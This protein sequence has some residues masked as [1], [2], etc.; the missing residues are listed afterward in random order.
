MHYERPSGSRQVA[1]EQ[2]PVQRK[3][4]RLRQDPQDSNLQNPDRAATRRLESHAGSDHRQPT[5][6]QRGDQTRSGPDLRSNQRTDTRTESGTGLEHGSETLDWTGHSDNR[7]HDAD[8]GA[9]DGGVSQPRDL[10]PEQHHEQAPELVAAPNPTATH[11]INRPTG[12][13]DAD[14]A[15]DLDDEIGGDLDDE[16]VTDGS[17]HMAEGAALFRPLELEI[18]GNSRARKP[19]TEKAYATNTRRLYKRSTSER[20]TD[21]Q[22][23]VVVTPLD[24]TEDLIARRGTGADQYWNLNRASLLW[25]LAKNRSQYEIFETAF[26]RLAATKQIRSS[27]PKRKATIDK[28]TIPES[29]LSQVIATLDTMN[30]TVSWGART[31]Y[32]LQAGLASGARPSEWVGARWLNETTKETLCLLNRK[33]KRTAPIFSLVG[34]GQTIHDVEEHNPERLVPGFEYDNETRIRHVPIENNAA[35]WVGLHMGT[36]NDYLREVPESQEEER[37][38]KYFNMCRKYLREAC[39]RAFNG[40][41]L[42]SLYVMRGQYAANMKAEHPLEEVAARMGHSPSGRTTMASYGP[43]SRAHGGRGVQTPAE[44]QAAAEARQA[45]ALSKAARTPTPKETDGSGSA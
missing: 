13:T 8:T 27:Q 3:S 1:S 34:P 42:Y 12:G 44:A 21:P 22:Q 31:R 39:L 36:L 10:I 38:K 19:S 18:E 43:R 4:D 35:F 41:R 5:D 30:R 45:R 37:Y 26:Q 32:W 40:K 25:H 2:D 14:P 20:S 9:P 24:V 7:D 29:D 23:P 17:G 15:S 33:R 16:I 6:Q 28:R 11:E